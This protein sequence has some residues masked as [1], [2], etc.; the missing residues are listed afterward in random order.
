M[1]MNKRIYEMEKK[2]QWR[3]YAKLEVYYLKRF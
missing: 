3:E 2:M 1:Q